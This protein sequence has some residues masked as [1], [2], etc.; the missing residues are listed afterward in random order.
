MADDPSD[1]PRLLALRA[2]LARHEGQ[3]LEASALVAALAECARTDV[4]A[5]F[6]LAE[7]ANEQNANVE[8]L[9]WLE[10]ALKLNPSHEPSLLMATRIL[11]QLDKQERAYKLLE[12]ACAADAHSFPPRLVLAEMLQEDGRFD[13]AATMYRGVLAVS[14]SHPAALAGLFATRRADDEEDLLARAQLVA[15][16]VDIPPGPRATL[17]YALA[18]TFDRRRNYEQ[19]F[20]HAEAANA[21]IR[22]N[23]P[24]D[25]G[26]DERRLACLMANLRKFAD[27]ELSLEET[28][29][30]RP[31]FI[32]G[33]P[34]SGTTL[35]EQILSGHS[36]VTG[37][38]ELPFW[39]A[40]AGRWKLSED[41]FDMPEV[42]RANV[43]A[44]R[45]RDLLAARGAT[46]GW[47]IDKLP[48]NYRFVSL[49]ASLLPDARF[50]HCVRD[51]RDNLVSIFF[52]HFAPHQTYTTGIDSIVARRLNH[53]RI[54]A[55]WRTLYSDKFLTLEY[56]A[57]AREGEPVVRR[58]V[59]WLGLS[60]E[61]ALMDYQGRVRSVRTPSRHQV[62]EPLY[63]SSIR[64]WKNYEP[65]MHEAFDALQS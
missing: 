56:E 63:D 7:L 32:V 62:R 20:I 14:P 54:T 11:R 57:L 21:L 16:S 55:E 50:I 42:D 31:L 47:V 41:G 23:R 59:E 1:H 64:R 13:E 2:R 18:K 5:A 30:A 24:H 4:R 45:Y 29:G 12:Q 51:P 15:E 10:N 8:A 28:A 39:P 17:N 33:M 65:W 53:D 52:E 46:E 27:V 49:I 61:D 60:W 36:E 19:A 26:E 25:A 22:R 38:G 40:V 35:V 9:G 58:V 48:D 3:A 6:S 43:A 34:R 37:L 44:Q